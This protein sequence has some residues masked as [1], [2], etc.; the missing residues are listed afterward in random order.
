MGFA[1]DRTPDPKTDPKI[2]P[3]TGNKRRR[4]IKVSI[5]SD[6][7]QQQGIASSP[8]QPGNLKAWEKSAKQLVWQLISWGPIGAGAVFAI[9][10][11]QASEFIPAILATLAASLWKVFTTLVNKVEE[12]LEQRADTLANWL[13]VQL[14]RCVLRLW[15]RATSK[16]Q[17]RYYQSLIYAC[18]DFRTQG[19][20]T[21]GPFTLDLEKVFVPLQLGPESAEHISPAL[22]Q[23]RN[24]EDSWGI[25]DFL[26]ALP[27]RVTY[28]RIAI[29][30]PPGSGKTTLLEHLTLTYAQSAQ[31][32]QHRRAPK[33]IPI[34]VYLRDIREQIARKPSISLAGLLQ[35]QDTIRKL[36]PPPQWF[37]QAL[38]SR[39]CLVM[40]DGLDEVADESQRKTVS[41]W[42]DRQMRAY[43]KAMFIL[44]SRPFGYRNSPIQ[45][46]GTVLEV[47]P[48]NLKQMQLFVRNWYLQNEIVRR[49]GKDDPGVRIE[50]ERKAEDLI[51]RIESSPP[52]AAMALNPL[53]LTMIA[54]VHDYRGALP[55]RRV[56]LY[57]EICDVL[58]GRRQESK[59]I[60]DSL[61]AAQKRSVLQVLALK[62]MQLQ[63]REFPL[64]AGKQM[65]R[66]S[67]TA[68]VGQDADPA[69]F[70]KL[71]EQ[72]SGLLIEREKGLYEFAHKSFQEYLAAAQIKELGQ[73]EVLVEHLSQPW[74][75]ET[76]RLYAAQSDVTL[77]LRA[78]LKRPNVTTLTLAFDCLEEGLS[79]HPEV[80]QRLESLLASGL[81]SQN[82]KLARLAATVKL[83]Q[84]LKQLLRLSRQL[85]ID[86]SYI[87]C[88]EYQLFVAQRRKQGENRRS[89]SW[90][91]GQFPAGMAARPVTGVRLG[92]AQAF[93]RWLTDCARANGLT[94]A[95]SYRLPTMAEL[96]EYPLSEPEM[97]G[98]CVVESGS[99][100][101]DVPPEQWQSWQ[102]HLQKRFARARDRDCSISH[103]LK[104]D[105]NRV[106]TL[107]Q[108]LEHACELARE[109]ASIHPKNQGDG[110]RSLAN[111]KILK[112]ARTLRY[113]LESACNSPQTCNAQTRD[114][115]IANAIERAGA[116]ER[117]LKRDLGIA[118]A[119]AR[120][121][122]PDRTRTLALNFERAL[123][124]GRARTLTQEIARNLERTRQLARI[125]D[126]IL[127][128]Q[129]EMPRQ[130]PL[131]L[132][133]DLTQL[134][135]TPL[136]QDFTNDLARAQTLKCDRKIDP[137]IDLPRDLMRNLARN[138]SHDLARIRDRSWDRSRSLSLVRAYLIAIATLW[139]CFSLRYA[140][141]ARDRRLLQTNKL[142]SQYCEK[143]SQDCASKSKKT[144]NLY[145]FLL[146]LEE[147]HNGRMPAWEGIR[148]VRET[149]IVA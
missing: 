133:A 60:A 74:W 7:L 143:V 56:E 130:L 82:P 67:L 9:N 88:A 5:M 139:Q 83:S 103:H 115:L 89:D 117:H 34:L 131:D 77:L 125:L 52:I 94:E 124:L 46:V 65:I 11:I 17:G 69:Q 15:W 3:K 71:I 73:G 61:T 25:W 138:L 12:K 21:K 59:G 79:V 6:H 24:T 145:S 121:L 84:R 78:I 28:R 126:G 23:S 122:S 33:L 106:R 13:V 92:D 132:R 40:L 20:K 113:T 128:L 30:G 108:T 116:L 8:P 123:D 141:I 53:L 32:R 57:A 129:K 136:V 146:L 97:G 50:A 93:C 36:N 98:W 80:R 14:E 134:L 2:G 118:H 140:K 16:F 114:R 144:D 68:V 51:G 42:V 137:P 135:S 70:L 37:E 90:Q 10:A 110:L 41:R 75:D 72:V 27:E 127:P 35:Q 86:T 4:L 85:E 49:L 102:E 100:I 26:A 81:E 104:R 107:E 142:T 55:G 96:Q 95:A 45:R 109:L 48:F 149:N 87:T 66:K 62:L 64:A 148:I 105:I 31:R 39:R 147:R 1:R 58:L 43:P 19:L 29:L 22:I 38:N 119:I 91:A 47:Q 111:Y 112:S 120:D 63:R 18:R 101:A 54:T 99:A 44:T 76:I